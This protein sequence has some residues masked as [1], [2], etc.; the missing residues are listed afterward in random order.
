MVEKTNKALTIKDYLVSWWCY[1]DKLD[2]YIDYDALVTG[3]SGENAIS[4]L[5][6]SNRL[7]VRAGKNFKAVEVEIK[8]IKRKQYKII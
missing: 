5:R 8:D 3:T 4:I 6:L 7:R 1:S 2:D